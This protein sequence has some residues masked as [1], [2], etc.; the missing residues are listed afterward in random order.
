MKATTYMLLALTLFQLFYK[1]RFQIIN[2]KIIMHKVKYF[3]HNMNMIRKTIST[4]KFIKDPAKK[5]NNS[6]ITNKTT[7]KCQKRLSKIIIIIN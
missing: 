1:S 4:E 5:E 2:L 7:I 6:T 3:L